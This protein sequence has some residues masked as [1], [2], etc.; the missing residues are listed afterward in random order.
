M[1]PGRQRGRHLPRRDRQREVPRH[2]QRDD[3]ERLAH[4]ER[5]RR[6]RPGSCRRGSAP[7]SRRSSGRCRPPSPS[8]RARRRSACRRCAPRAPRAPRAPPRA[9][10]PARSSSRDA[11]GGR[12][13]RARPGTPPRAR[14]TA[15]SASSTPARGTSS[16][17]ASVAG[18]MTSRVPLSR[19][20]RAGLPGSATVDARRRPSPTLRTGPLNVCRALDEPPDADRGEDDADGERRVVD[21]LPVEVVVPRR[22]GR[23]LRQRED[24]H[25]DRR[26]RRSPRGLTHLYFLPSVHGPGLERVAHA[27]AQVRRHDVGDVEADHRDRDDGVERVRCSRSRRRCSA[28]SVMTIA[29]KHGEEDGERRARGGG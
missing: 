5:L 1:L 11:V 15:A 7:A 6:R 18:S 19:Y 14:A 21:V 23:A 20:G 17:T 27:P 3:A 28:G 29:Q 13:G 9:A 2:D 25:A 16:S 24:D 26:P 10:R 22:A 4:R 12:D 8:R